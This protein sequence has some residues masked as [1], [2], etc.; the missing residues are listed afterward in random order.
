M[1]DA[2]R[3]CICYI[4]YDLQR[5]L[6][7]VCKIE[8]EDTVEGLVTRI[9][10]NYVETKYGKGTLADA[11]RRIASKRKVAEESELDLLRAPTAFL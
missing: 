1:S 7:L 3:D 8:A 5:E 4:S 9:L 11:L 2:M 6:R 10:D